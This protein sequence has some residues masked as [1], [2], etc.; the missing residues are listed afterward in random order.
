MTHEPNQID[1]EADT[2]RCPQC[3][4]S[5]P[6]ETLGGLCPRC[7]MFQ[8]AGETEDGETSTPGQTPPNIE[9]VRSAFPQLEVI[10]LIGQGGMGAVYKA[11]QKSLNRLIAIKLL[12]RQSDG[13]NDFEARFT[14]EA[15]ALAELNHPNIVTIHDFGQAGGYYFLMMEYV[16]GVNLRQA[17]AAGRLAPEQALSIVPPVCEA[18]TFA[19]RRGIVHRDIKPENLLLDRAGNVK[20]A[21]FGIARIVRLSADESTSSVN[22]NSDLATQDMQ[23]TGAGVLGTPNYMA[24]EQTQNPAAV[25][26]RAD[27]YSLGVVLYEMLTGEVPRGRFDVPSRKVAVDVRLD[28]IV[29]RALDRDPELRWPTTAALKSQ[30][31][32]LS[33]DQPESDSM[34]DPFQSSPFV[35]GLTFAATSIVLFLLAAVFLILFCSLLGINERYM[36]AAML[37]FGPLS[38]IASYF[39]LRW[40]DSLA[41]RQRRSTAER[42]PRPLLWLAWLSALLAL[43]VG[44]FGIF[45]F[46]AFLD[47]PQWNP[48]LAEAIIVI[49]SWFGT[50]TLPVSSWWLFRN[51]GPFFDGHLS[52]RKASSHRQGMTAAGTVCLLFA[53]ALP[54]AGFRMHDTEQTRQLIE[55]SQAFYHLN[56]QLHALESVKNRLKETQDAAMS[57]G[58]SEPSEMH[59]RVAAK[60]R[61]ELARAN[62]QI[63]L[64]RQELELQT[65]QP[66]LGMRDTAITL[67]LVG[68]LLG[69]C[70]VVV[71]IAVYVT[72]WKWKVILVTL[73]VL[74]VL[75]IGG[76][77]IRSLTIARLV[78]LDGA[79]SEPTEFLPL[80]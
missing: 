1:R 18:L 11:R 61:E 26:Q 47:D 36:A 52:S 56:Q 8:A 46:Q 14:R 58:K 68:V 35:R 28:E 39:I 10:E 30:L 70:G 31:E 50:I 72:R 34:A 66:L 23:L 9:D 62:A 21:D 51:G 20:I 16:D 64:L 22:A 78:V 59:K 42:Q 80:K 67:S 40:N 63:A 32:S 19:H 65:E 41:A 2:R 77:A 17:M 74:G 79:A 69:I 7:M 53:I 3:G 55:Q 6:V 76:T 24:P 27:V 4:S 73:G 57:D 37:L 12:T 29:L 49:L 38:L 5:V 60:T 75:A 54:I 13:T 15:R 33:L 48:I 45:F 25:D 44:L 71:L 43:P